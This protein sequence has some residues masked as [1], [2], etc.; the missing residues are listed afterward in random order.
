MKI[1]NFI[2]L[3]FIVVSNAV[4]AAENRGIATCI[5]YSGKA[6]VEITQTFSSLTY[7]I[8]DQ[9]KLTLKLNGKKVSF[10]Y[11]QLSNL[12]VSPYLVR[13][14]SPLIIMNLKNDGLESVLAVEY[15]GKG[16]S[17]NVMLVPGDILGETSSI[18]KLTQ[19]SC[20]SEVE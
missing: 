12:Y 11:E 3:S 16:N 19:I 8:E 20:F 9:N 10:D 14:S 17:R 4:F 2:V 6:K 1:F 13:K 7:R 5:G 15:L 18:V